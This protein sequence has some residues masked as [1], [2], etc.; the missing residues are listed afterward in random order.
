MEASKLN[1]RYLTGLI[2]TDIVV[3]FVPLIVFHVH[4]PD[5]LN[6]AR[7]S[8][9]DHCFFCTERVRKMRQDCT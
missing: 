9:V 3:F 2:T 8:H 1:H 7:G 4:S 6:M 5:L